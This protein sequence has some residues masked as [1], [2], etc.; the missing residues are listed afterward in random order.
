MKSLTELGDQTCGRPGGTTVVDDHVDRLVR[1]ARPRS[2]ECPTSYPTVAAGTDRS[3]PIRTHRPRGSRPDAA[4]AQACPSVS[5]CR[6]T[7]PARSPP[8]GTRIGRLIVRPSLAAARSPRHPVR[9][10][11][12]A[13]QLAV[14]REEHV[15]PVL[16]GGGSADLVVGAVHAAVN[17][18]RRPP[19]DPVQGHED[20]G[21][22]VRRRPR[23][24][25]RA[26]AHPSSPA[27]QAWSPTCGSI[28]ISHGCC[29]RDQAHE[30]VRGGRTTRREPLLPR[31]QRHLLV[32]TTDLLRDLGNQ[33]IALEHR[34]GVKVLP[35]PAERREL[36]ELRGQ[37]GA[38]GRRQP[39]AGAVHDGVLAE[40]QDPPA[41]EQGGGP[42]IDC[43]AGLAAEPRPRFLVA[44]RHATAHRAQPAAPPSKSETGELHDRR[45]E[46]IGLRDDREPGLLVV[47]RRLDLGGRDVLA[48]HGD[49]FR[50]SPARGRIFHRGHRARCAVGAWQAGGLVARTLDPRRRLRRRSDSRRPCGARGAV[51]DRRH[52]VE[53]VAPPRARRLRARAPPS[54]HPH[55][56]GRPPP[57]RRLPL[58]GRPRS[59]RSRTCRPAAASPARPGPGRR[60]G[61]RR[62]RRGPAARRAPGP[63]ARTRAAD[64]SASG[65]VSSMI[66]TPSAASP[67]S[68]SDFGPAAPMR[69]RVGTSGGQS[70]ATSSSRTYSPSML[71]VSPASS[72]R[73]ATRYSPISVSGDDARAPTWPIHS[74]TPCPTAG[75]NRPPCIRSS[76]AI[77]IAVAATLRSGHGQQPEPHHQP[78]RLGEGGCRGG[79]AALEEA[80]LPQPHLLEPDGLGVPEEAAHGLR[81]GLRPDDD[82]HVNCHASASH[83]RDAVAGR[84]SALRVA[85][86]DP[87][88]V[89]V[90]R[91]DGRACGAPPARRRSIR[92]VARAPA[93]AS[94]LRPARPRGRTRAPRATP[95][96]ARSTC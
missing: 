13:T 3:G 21:W 93:G 28:S 42:A 85:D 84:L 31:R 80:V 52:L 82:T 44:Q 39:D 15:H 18:H 5:R 12:A 9:V 35:A 22:P 54:S 45:C 33:A 69:M 17:A 67:A 20:A 48:N 10:H 19:V 53:V 26:L 72:L 79:H 65:E 4:T 60:G 74:C 51:H 46:L 40:R 55:R 95:R 37:A 75:R 91:D 36:L 50:S 62:R 77:S 56:R 41:A 34:P 78:L 90:I 88:S 73:R 49:S 92:P 68:A 8:P 66:T 81:R 11:I 23:T 87:S 38:L 43:P 14:H 70:R 30:G 58:T 89:I 59:C 25:C 61:R 27:S 2:G 86:G 6:S 83:S 24:P 94:A 63:P 7:I 32:R 16:V 96:A 57:G 29:S 76:V 1:H 71:T 47:V 64:R